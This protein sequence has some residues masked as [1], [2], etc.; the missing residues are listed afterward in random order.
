MD[1]I[2]APSPLSAHSYPS[3]DLYPRRQ[4]A[5]AQPVEPCIGD[6]GWR[7]NQ[8]IDGQAPAGVLQPTW[9][10]WALGK[11]KLRGRIGGWG[12]INE[13]EGA[14]PEH[15]HSAQIPFNN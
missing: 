9:G 12:R 14:L 10:A 15:A 2:C 6:S 8:T 1:G 3:L 5:S 11:M 7:R 4:C 13:E